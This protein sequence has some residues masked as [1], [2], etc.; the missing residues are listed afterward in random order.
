MRNTPYRVLVVDD[1]LDMCEELVA[2]LEEHQF[3]VET[4]NHGVAGWHG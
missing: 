4:A 3:T 1:K 2:L